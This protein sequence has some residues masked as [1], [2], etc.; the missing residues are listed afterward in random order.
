MLEHAKELARRFKYGGTRS[1]YHLDKR[2][3]ATIHDGHFK[4]VY[5][6]YAIVYVAACERRK[7]VLDRCDHDALPHQRRSV[8]DTRDVL[9][10][11]WYL[12]II[13]VNSAENISGVGRCRFERYAGRLACVQPV[14]AC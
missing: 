7:Q 14:S 6:D 13:Q 5:L 11:G 3:G 8:A 10:R 1:L 12:E 2:L 9:R 4:R